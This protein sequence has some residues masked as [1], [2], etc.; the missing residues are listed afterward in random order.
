MAEDLSPF[1][2][3][4]LTC[5][6]TSS[7][8]RASTKSTLSRTQ[9]RPGAHG[10]SVEPKEKRTQFFA[11]EAAERAGQS[12]ADTAPNRCECP[13]L[14]AHSPGAVKGQPQ[15]PASPLQSRRIAHAR[16][17]PDSAPP[18]R[19]LQRARRR[20]SA[21]GSRRSRCLSVRW[22]LGPWGAAASG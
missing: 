1:V 5:C 22:D 9:G 21:G 20:R 2:V 7:S 8:L 17:R 19:D 13:K 14:R 16:R 3:A 10:Y 18:G 15:A 11:E 4:S 12:D 6:R